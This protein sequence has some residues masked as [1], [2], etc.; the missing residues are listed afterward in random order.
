MNHHEGQVLL[1]QLT[2]SEICIYFIGWWMFK[3]RM[4][5]FLLYFKRKK[6][7][8]AFWLCVHVKIC[9]QFVEATTLKMSNDPRLC[10]GHFERKSSPKFP[11]F[12]KQ[13]FFPSE[14]CF[15]IRE[16]KS[17]NKYILIRLWVAPRVIYFFRSRNPPF[18]FIDRKPRNFDGIDMQVVSYGWINK[19]NLIQTRY[20]LCVFGLYILV[21]TFSE[22]KWMQRLPDQQWYKMELSF[23][24]T[25]LS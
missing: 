18:Q 9:Q 1:S 15:V 10:H 25:L 19:Y 13:S 11:L 14:F 3:K 4:G 20:G 21:N 24:R 6:R 2:C 8:S 16:E 22:R 5:T 7:N 17:F 23:K 12:T